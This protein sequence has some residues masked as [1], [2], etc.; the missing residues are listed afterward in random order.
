MISIV[1]VD[2]KNEEMPLLKDVISETA[3]ILTDEHW[4]KKY[5]SNTSEKDK[6]LE[7]EPLMDFGCFD[8]AL[9][10]MLSG[11]PDVRSNYE[12][13]GM[14]LIADSDMSPMEYLKPGIRADALLIRPLR[15]KELK[16]TMNEFISSGLKRM[17]RDEDSD[18]VFVLKTKEG[19]TFIP[20]DNIY[21]F[22][23]REKKVFIRLLNE[24]IPFYS[25]IDELEGMLPDQF[26]RCHRSFIVNVNRIR[27]LIS[28]ENTIELQQD[29]MIPLSRT[30]KQKLKERR[31]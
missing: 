3:A 23:A 17:D 10:G 22:E 25:T 7:S 28:A 31:P 2:G 8:V 16:T 6:Y 19:R 13:M 21:Y 11:L 15:I 12:D 20:Y 24:E 5:F 30:Y 29:F 18:D 9:D 26:A 14:L 27:K 4:E 1:T